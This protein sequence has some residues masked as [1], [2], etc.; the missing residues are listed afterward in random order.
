MAHL[1][2][3]R[4]EAGGPYTEADSRWRLLRHDLHKPAPISS[5][6]IQ[7]LLHKSQLWSTIMLRV[8]SVVR[9]HDAVSTW[10]AVTRAF[11]LLTRLSCPALPEAA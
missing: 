11:S 2:A 6:I 10:R 4:P 5:S 3:F 7:P 8:P 9:P 1:M